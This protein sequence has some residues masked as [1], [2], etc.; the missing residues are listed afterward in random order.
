[1]DITQTSIAKPRLHKQYKKIIMKS[2]IYLTAI[3]SLIILLTSCEKDKIVTTI[4]QPKLATEYS[5]EDGILHF[6]SDSAFIKT[7]DKLS[8]MQDDEFDAWEASIGFKS[9][10]TELDLVYDEMD[11]CKDSLSFEKILER[12][13]DILH[14]VE[15]AIVPKI[16][17][18]TY[19][20]F[21]TREG[22][23][24]IETTLYKVQEGKI[25]ISIDG[26]INGI[27]KALDSGST[28][29]NILLLDYY[30]TAKKEGEI[31]TKSIDKSEQTRYED[32]ITHD[33]RRCKLQIIAVY[34]YS[35]FN[36]YTSDL[37]LIHTERYVDVVVRNYKK[38]WGKYRSYNTLCEMRNISFRLEDGQNGYLASLESSG[39]VKTLSKTFNFS[40][41]NQ[42]V[43]DP[44]A[45]D[46][47]NALDGI[48]FD[49]VYGQ[50]T[51]RGVGAR[52]VVVN[53]DDIID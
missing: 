32:E 48:E 39:E 7:I 3:L 47:F 25:A 2:K 36:N 11:E 18:T 21:L 37:T 31:T 51:N 42:Y 52:W 23:Y 44:Y 13:N 50:A 16:E 5:V 53:Q 27:N 35:L 26:D 17:S 41:S 40:F 12:N 20:N 33:K 24:Y 34:T 1:M 22:M 30:Q 19:A 38:S 45:A 46:V 8:K 9:L 6:S 4:T 28:S 43:Y 14:T 15:D 29:N 10:R 49:N